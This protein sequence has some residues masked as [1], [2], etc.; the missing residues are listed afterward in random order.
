MFIAE[1]KTKSPFGFISNKSWDEL[2]NIADLFGDI[3]SIHTDPR[4][5]GKYERITEARQ[6][7][8]RPILAKGIHSTDDDIIK[9]LDHGAWN[10]LVVGRIPK[11]SLLKYCIIEPLNLMQLQMVPSDVWCVWNSRNLN[12]GKLK[13]ETWEEARS[14]FKGVLIQASNI[15][16]KIDVKKDAQGYIVGEHLDNFT[17]ETS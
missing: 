16:T 6:K 13:T 5:G 15:K 12:T 2:L 17:K 8:R 7:S 4:W 3:I 10:V 14:L 9:A 1:V 11:T